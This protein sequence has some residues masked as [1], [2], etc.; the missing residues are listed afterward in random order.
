M[1][2]DLLP[3]SVY[4]FFVV[5]VRMG[6]CIALLPGM[7]EAYVAMRS[8]LALALAVSFVLTPVLKSTVPPE[9]QNVQELVLL[10]VGEATI[11][12][13]IGLTARIILGTTS[14][15]GMIV[16]NMMSLS[17]AF[18]N[19]PT[20]VQQASIVGSFLSSVALVLVFATGLHRLFFQALVGSYNL[21]VPG[22]TLLLGDMSELIARLAASTFKLS[23]Q[24][25]LP[26]LVVAVVFFVGLGILAKLM[27]QMQVF[28]VA[29]PV[30]I[31]MGLVIFLFSVATMMKIFA[32]EFEQIFVSLLSGSP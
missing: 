19:D 6:A 9:P 21:F 25:S 13:F 12:T 29:M 1:F 32:L 23:V 14:T 24:M 31:L 11:G 27:P 30:Q 10:I 15:A 22:Q 5:F 20:S 16:A 4:V 28:F 3:A 2:A 17:N 8:R 18:S 7:G 26:F